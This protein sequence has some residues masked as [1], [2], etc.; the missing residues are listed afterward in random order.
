[1]GCQK[2]R[3]ESILFG[4]FRKKKPVAEIAAL[5]EYTRECKLVAMQIADDIGVPVEDIE[6][7]MCALERARRR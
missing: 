2:K 3:G 1:M 4:W 6:K 5:N 7:L